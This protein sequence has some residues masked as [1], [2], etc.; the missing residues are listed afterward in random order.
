M[1]GHVFS[2]YWNGLFEIQINST[3]VLSRTVF[4]RIIPAF[5]KVLLEIEKDWWLVFWAI[6]DSHNTRNLFK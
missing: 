6:N 1:C 4:L 3:K 5:H 2:N